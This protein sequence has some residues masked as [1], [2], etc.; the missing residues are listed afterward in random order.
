MTNEVPFYVLWQ[1]LVLQA[2]LLFV[3]FS[4][5]T[6]SLIVARLH[7]VSRVIFADGYKTAAVLEVV[8]DGVKSLLYSC[9][10]HNCYASGCCSYSGTSFFSSFFAALCSKTSMIFVSWI[11]AKI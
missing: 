6:L 5:D 10:T 11:A 2:N 1:C 3:R 9:F 8:K 4:E 7:H